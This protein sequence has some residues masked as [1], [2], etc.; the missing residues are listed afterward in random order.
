MVVKAVGDGWLK[1]RCR[2]SG[3]AVPMCRRLQR[4][5]PVAVACGECDDG[6]GC[7]AI[8]GLPAAVE[9]AAVMASGGP[10]NGGWQ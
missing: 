10:G 3:A 5:R 9:L 7:A 4:G 6:V 1:W 8:R 2:W